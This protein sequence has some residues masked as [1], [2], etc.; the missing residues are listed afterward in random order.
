MIETPDFQRLIKDLKKCGWTQ[1][2]I[3]DAV[4]T[5][6]IHISRLERGERKEPRAGLALR[7]M[8]LH[9]REMANVKRRKAR[10][11]AA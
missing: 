1:V 8:D 5:S 2:R 7:I 6:Q 4:E 10:R 9:K 11:D 3:A